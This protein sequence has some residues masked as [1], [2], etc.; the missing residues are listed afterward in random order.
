MMVFEADTGSQSE[1][2]FPKTGVPSPKRL[3]RS[4]SPLEETSDLEDADG[5]PLPSL[6]EHQHRMPRWHACRPGET[7]PSH[8][9]PPS[10]L[11]PPGP[12]AASCLGMGP[13]DGGDFLRVV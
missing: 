12:T 7:S 6:R 8:R 10:P 2:P 13:R 3:N 9:L 5:S 4:K 1:E 11:P